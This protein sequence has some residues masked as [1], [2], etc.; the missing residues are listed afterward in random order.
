[1]V[2]IVLIFEAG[3]AP[4]LKQYGAKCQIIEVTIENDRYGITTFNIWPNTLIPTC[5]S[6]YNCEILY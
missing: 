3:F 2:I 4:V 6:G 1:M 5:I